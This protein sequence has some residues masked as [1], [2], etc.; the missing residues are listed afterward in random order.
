MCWRSQNERAA[1]SLRE[2]DMQW[3]VQLPSWV[4]SRN[5]NYQTRSNLFS[6]QGDTSITKENIHSIIRPPELYLHTN[7][8][9]SALCGE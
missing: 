8:Q 6:A 2:S 4:E 9:E 7:W 5:I 3:N 1:A